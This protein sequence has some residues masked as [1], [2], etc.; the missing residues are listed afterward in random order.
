MDLGL[1]NPSHFIGASSR[2]QRR[3]IQRQRRDPMPDGDVR[4]ACCGI[5]SFENDVECNISITFWCIFI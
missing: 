4:C 2:W 3:Q 1:F 5:G